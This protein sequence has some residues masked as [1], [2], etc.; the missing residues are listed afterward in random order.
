[1]IKEHIRKDRS[2][3]LCD[4]SKGISYYLKS[5]RNKKLLIYDEDIQY[6]R[7]IRHC[8]NEKSIYIDEQSE[9]AVVS[10]II[11]N[12]GLLQVYL[13][14][15]ITQEFLNKHP[16]N[17]LIF[18]EIDTLKEDTK[19]V[20]RDELILEIKQTILSKSKEEEGI[21]YLEMVVSKLTGSYEQSSKKTITEL[22]RILYQE[23]ENN[24]EYF[25]DKNGNINVFDNEA[26]IRQYIT[27]NALKSGVIKKSMN[28]T[29][30]LWT[31][32]NTEIV[33]APQGINLVDYFSDYLSTDNGMLVLQEI[34]RRIK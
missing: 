26:L 5:G 6:K 19:Y 22:K 31:K 7:P 21:L 2:Y 29:T 27:L 1:M 4:N 23:A 25:T 9:H 30:M 20:D 13:T 11:F 33:T 14:D 34:E 12:Q 3:K 15:P 28:G 8:P 16:D 24:P 17:G 18:E 10:P 32:D